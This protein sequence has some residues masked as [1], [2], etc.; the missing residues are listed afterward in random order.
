MYN[1]RIKLLADLKEAAAKHKC[2]IPDA[3]AFAILNNPSNKNVLGY[4]DGY[5]TVP[6]NHV[7]NL[8]AEREKLR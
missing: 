7:D 8:I 1:E 6:W 3:A 2:D 4:P 5:V